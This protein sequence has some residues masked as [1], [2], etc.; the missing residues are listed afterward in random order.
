MS[1]QRQHVRQARYAPTTM[2]APTPPEDPD[3]LWLGAYDYELPAAAIAQRPAAERSGSRLMVID[4]A[5]GAR[6][7]ARF[8]EIGRFLRAGD[9]LVVNDAKV[10]PARLHGRKTS[11]G[12]VEVLLLGAEGAGVFIGLLRSSRRPAPGTTIHFGATLTCMVLDDLGGGR[13][14]LRFAGAD[15]L[16][17]AIRGSAELPLPPY[18]HREH[19]P[20]ADDVE[21]YQTVYADVPGSVAAPTAGLHFTRDLIADLLARGIEMARVTL[22]VGPATFQPIRTEDLRRHELEGEA[23]VIGP[24]AAR[25]MAAARESGRRV[26]AVGT[27]TTRVLEAACDAG[28]VVL[29]GAGVARVFI[30]PGYRFRAVDGLITNFHLPRSSLLVLVS[31]FLGRRRVLTAYAEALACGYR[32]YS[33]GDAMAI[34][35]SV[36]GAPAACQ[37]AA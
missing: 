18:I 20:D 25:A 11:G 13:W 8:G 5:T 33:Y 31:A 4:A 6:T 22:H 36:G 17:A 2:G 37:G 14:R 10:D 30:G 26:I 19:G 12:S 34:L 3:D 9:L 1:A 32:F 28:G 24:D 15:D 27:T 21:R 23:Y 35:P 29:A 16:E 7:H